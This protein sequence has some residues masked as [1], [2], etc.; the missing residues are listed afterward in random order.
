LRILFIINPVSGH[1][2]KDDFIKLLEQ[3]SETAN[4]SYETYLTGGINDF[5]LVEKI[6]LRFKP[7]IIAGVGGDG[8]INMLLPLLVKYNCKLGIIP[9]GS[10]N[11]MATE[12]NL[13]YEIDEALNIILDGHFTEV[14][15]L[16]VNNQY[17]IHLA[18]IGL[19]ARIIKRFEKEGKRGLLNYGKQLVIELFYIRS[20]VYKIVPD[21]KD[22]LNFKAISITIANASKFGSGAIINPE[23]K[24]NDGKFELCII[25]PFPLIYIFILMFKF[26]SGRLKTSKYVE[27][28]SCREALI[29]C[30]KKLLVHTDGE[31]LGRHQLIHVT[32]IP[33]KIKIFAPQIIP[34]AIDIT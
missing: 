18:D 23:S 22:I 2:N 29:K 10:A 32:V 20:Q 30:N 17:T 33:Q 12:L 34:I 11:G 9:L 19:N 6:Y 26:F 15:V 24:L 8:T 1:K 3:K 13:P 4:F 21:N 5:F 27:I 31:L 14:D 7:D 25:K 28:I 16:K